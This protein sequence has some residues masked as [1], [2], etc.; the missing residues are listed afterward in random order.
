MNSYRNFGPNDDQVQPVGDRAFLGLDLRSDA[1]TLPAGI[2]ARSENGRMETYGWQVRAGIARQLTAGDTVETIFCAGVYR[3]ADDND[4]IAMVNA[5]RLTLFNPEDQS[6]ARYDYPAGQTVTVD[7]QV[8]LIQGGVSVG[9]VPDLYILRGFD[10]AVLKFNGSSVAVD[11]NFR[12]GRT[13]IFTQD[14][15]AVIDSLWSIAA[16]DYL[17]FT[18]WSALAQFNITKGGDEYLVHL[19]EYQKDYVL[20]G[21]R[22]RWFIAHFDPQVSTTQGVGYAGGLQDTSFLRSLTRE[23][24]IVGKRASAEVNGRIWVVKDRSIYAF[25]PRLDNELTVL[26]EPIGADIQPLLDRM[27]SDFSERCSIQPLGQ[28]VYCALAISAPK[29]KISS[30]VV[31]AEST[32]LELPFDLPAVLGGGYIVTLTTETDHGLATGDLIQITGAIDDGVNGRRRL[33][34]SV[35]DSRTFTIDITDSNGL[36]VGE[37]AYVQKIAERPNCIAVWNLA[38]PTPPGRSSD[39]PTGNWESIDFL[40]SGVFADFLVLADANGSRRLWL[41]DED[42]GPCLYEEGET[43]EITDEVGGL[44]LPFDLPAE[45]SASNFGSVPVAG[46]L[47]SRVYQWGELSREVKNGKVRVNLAGDDAGTVT[48]TVRTP[49][50]TPYVAAKDFDGLTQTDDT[51]RVRAGRRGIEAD[52]ELVSTSGRPAVRALTVEVM[53]TGRDKED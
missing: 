12:K 9:T 1:T 7:D 51:L 26:G 39:R 23:G 52:L 21:S 43:D 32:A 35:T 44:S 6:T 31:G 48:L 40:P 17:D 11:S 5:S 50:R 47:K 30:V 46:A 4:R 13:G 24:G 20:I 37:R 53:N 14:R 19:R 36:G 41:V 25:V 34:T 28:R 29:V 27:S 33:V 18:T 8:E 3:P 16:S 38:L 45:L 49:G 42:L 22:K 2:V 10:K 15:M